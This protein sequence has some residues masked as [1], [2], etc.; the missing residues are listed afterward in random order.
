MFA[1]QE[2]KGLCLTE[3]SNFKCTSGDPQKTCGQGA[4]PETLLTFLFPCFSSFHQLLF[5]H[6]YHCLWYYSI[7][8]FLSLSASLGPSL[9]LVPTPLW[10]PHFHHCHCRA[11]WSFFHS[12]SSIFTLRGSPRQLCWPTK[13]FP[14]TG[15]LCGFSL[16][17]SLG[18]SVGLPRLPP[19]YRF[20]WLDEHSNGQAHWSSPH[21]HF[22]LLAWC[23]SR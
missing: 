18:A 8:L 9:S 10:P 17:A 22:W 23:G 15:T 20:W 12:E 3:L 7:N 2:Q 16:V 1:C 4:F 21:L 19:Y 13:A 11:Q 14:H 6:A 5:P